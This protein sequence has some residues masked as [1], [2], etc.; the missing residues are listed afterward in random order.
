MPLEHIP[1]AHHLFAQIVFEVIK[2]ILSIPL[3]PNR[4]PITSLPDLAKN[5]PLIHLYLVQDMQYDANDAIHILANLMMFAP[6]RY[7]SLKSSRSQTGILLLYSNLI[8]HVPQGVL[9]PVSDHRLHHTAVTAGDPDSDSDSDSEDIA[10]ASAGLWTPMVDPKTY[11][12]VETIHSS[13]HLSSISS[14][15]RPAL[16]SLVLSLSSKFSL[17]KSQ[18]YWAL[19]NG[20]RGSGFIR[21]IWRESIRSFSFGQD[22]NTTE[23]TG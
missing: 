13:A 8:Q 10:K 2:D 14:F 22:L 18:I 17:R 1:A 4:L 11:K 6:P 12:R 16:I 15:H 5:L 23:L 21:E 19:L 9:S 20:K 3:L 7:P